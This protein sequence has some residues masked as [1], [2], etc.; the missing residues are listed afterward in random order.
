MAKQINVCVGGVVKTVT[1]VPLGV[2]GVVKFAK[3]GVCGVGGVVKEFYTNTIQLWDGTNYLN[4]ASNVSTTRIKYS[5]AE[6]FLVGRTISVTIK[7]G[8]AS[9]YLMTVECLRGGTIQATHYFDASGNL[10]LDYSNNSS[11]NAGSTYNIPLSSI[12]DLSNYTEVY[13]G[14][15]NSSGYTTFKNYVSKLE[16]N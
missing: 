14:F 12:S 4:G 6:G 15:R 2:G 3:K 9:N 10:G 7:G 1:K 11:W 13:I 16:L 5:D 8:L